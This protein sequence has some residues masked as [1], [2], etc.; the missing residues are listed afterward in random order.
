MQTCTFLRLF[1]V[2]V[3][4]TNMQKQHV[5]VILGQSWHE[6]QSPTVTK[7]PLLHSLEIK[8]GES[9]KT[10]SCTWSNFWLNLNVSKY[11]LKSDSEGER[12]HRP[13]GWVQKNYSLRR[14]RNKRVI[15]KIRSEMKGNRCRTAALPMKVWNC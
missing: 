13:F 6:P 4:I 10:C 12:N 1:Y 11:A 2:L 14:V 8:K 15:F 7:H 9:L 3:S 5:R